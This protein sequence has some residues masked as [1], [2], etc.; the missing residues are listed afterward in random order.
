[1]M[2]DSG[3]S[4]DK[5][6]DYGN[7]WLM[8][9]MARECRR[10]TVTAVHAYEDCSLWQFIEAK[11]LG[12]TCI[13]DM[14]TCFYRTWETVHAELR[15]KYSEWELPG[16]SPSTHHQRLEQKRE[17]IALAD[18]T[19]VASRYVESTIREFYPLK[20][21]ARVPY[22]VDLDFWAQSPQQKPTGPLRFIYAGQI[23]LRKG[24]PFLIEAWSKAQLRDARLILVGS[25]ALAERKRLA[26]PSG[27]EWH[28]PCS[29]LDL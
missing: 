6:S 5:L 16:R 2:R 12:K 7:R 28:P 27:V 25:W 4:G 29:S 10:P 23:S 21:I 22:G 14:P 1:M 20:H 15:A 13:Y 18:I 3:Y 19:F 11:R 8:R 17:E 9:T 24:I 26:L